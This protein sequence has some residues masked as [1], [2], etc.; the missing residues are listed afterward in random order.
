MST[1]LR[2]PIA[3]VALAPQVAA[4]A[5]VPTGITGTGASVFI[6]IIAAAMLVLLVGGAAARPFT[7]KLGERATR[8]RIS[9]ELARRSKFVIS[10]ALLPGAYG[11][12]VKLDHVVLTPAALLCIRSVHAHGLLAGGKN[13]PQWTLIEGSAKRRFLNPLIHNEGRARALRKAVPDVPVASLVVVSGKVRVTAQPPP[14]VIS[15][16]QLDDRLKQQLLGPARIKDLNAVW[17]QLQSAIM[18]DAEA[19]KD[20]AAQVSFS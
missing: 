4:A 7:R 8:Y 9:R 14:N 10:N 16:G 3:V 13:E 19:R 15:L 17:Q 12:I 2:K 11:G 20:F 1:K 18:N 6:F 5:S